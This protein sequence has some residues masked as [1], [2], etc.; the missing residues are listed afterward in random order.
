M[1]KGYVHIYTGNGKGKSTA[2]FGLAIR[3]ACAGNAVY[4]G[5]FVKDMAYSETKIS[6]F[7]PSIKVETLG[8][9]CFIEHKPTENDLLAAEAALKKCENILKGDQYQL[10]ILDEINIAIYF[11]LIDPKKVLK[12]LKE[13][14]PSIEV[15]LTGRYAVEDLIDYA[16]LVTEMT[17]IKHYYSQG[18]LSREGIDC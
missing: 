9:G 17:E 13:R 2:A 5:Q 15:V 10:V 12:I 18:V 3:S 16:D 1:E 8:L 6:M 11:K 4:I 7:L 14:N